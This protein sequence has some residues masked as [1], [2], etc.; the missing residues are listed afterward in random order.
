MEVELKQIL[1]L[2]GAEKVKA[3]AGYVGDV[4]KSLA[5]REAGERSFVKAIKETATAEQMIKGEY[6]QEAAIIANFRNVRSE[7]TKAMQS[8]NSKMMKS[9]FETGQELRNF[10]REQRVVNRTMRET[11]N[12]VQEMTGIFGGGALS[13][14]IGTLFSNF[15]TLHFAVE[16]S[17]IAAQGAGGK[18]ASFGETLSTLGL[19]IVGIAT[20]IM[21]VVE[22]FHKLDEAAAKAR[23][24]LH[25]T[26]TETATEYFNL[27]KGQQLGMR[28]SERGKLET[29]VLELTGQRI[30]LTDM[31]ATN[32][33]DKEAKEMALRDIDRQILE[34]NKQIR[35]IDVK[36]KKLKDEVLEAKKDADAEARKKGP[37][38]AAP[39]APDVQ[40]V[41]EE[42]WYWKTH[43]YTVSDA[44]HQAIMKGQTTPLTWNELQGRS[45]G[46]TKMG[47]RGI[48]MGVSQP[49]IPG[50][51]TGVDA[52][53]AN[54][55]QAKDVK[56]E[57]SEL[58]KEQQGFLTGMQSAAHA[59]ASNVGDSFRGALSKAFGD[60]KTL[61]DQMLISFASSIADWGL[62]EI[63]GELLSF[64]PGGGLL[65]KAAGMAGGGVITEPY[66]AKGMHTGNLLMLGER[67]PELVT[68][69][70][71]V[72][73]T[74]H[75]RTGADTG[76]LIASVDGL[77]SYIAGG[78]WAM[79]GTQLSFLNDRVSRVYKATKM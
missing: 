29:D 52:K 68:P 31:T 2:E 45:Q 66:I 40:L 8:D 53:P 61:F 20:G 69:M 43:S 50:Q 72:T 51:L 78:S 44:M 4:T 12:A 55:A 33:F 15:H 30:K 67:G 37:G 27:S 77:V 26:F 74:S 9:Y 42:E 38:F 28:T 36:V 11:S 41:D 46:S 18:M 49:N 22:T 65:K 19:P 3:L 5:A 7:A 16:G 34:K 24:E 25:K 63:F 23:E 64:L 58:G 57:F 47:A 21:F 14:S 32:V 60:G 73:G 13:S 71:R 54:W 76:A 17:A 75:S 62:N 1:K 56:V 70:N 79:R 39:A 10:Y 6:I 35:E 48:G 59:A